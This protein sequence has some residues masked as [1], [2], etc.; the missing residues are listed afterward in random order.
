MRYKGYDYGQF[1]ELVDPHQYNTRSII[2]SP[3]IAFPS[4]YILS[5][6]PGYLENNDQYYE[7]RTTRSYLYDK[8]CI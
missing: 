4:L 6:K 8:I 5:Y 3:L 1:H 7:L 2:R